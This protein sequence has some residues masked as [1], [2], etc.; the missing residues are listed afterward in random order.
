IPNRTETMKMLNG[1]WEW[2]ETSFVSRGVAPSQKTP[3]TTGR[4]VVVTFKPDNQALVFVQG[5]L[6]GTFTYKLSQ[7]P[8]DYV[9]ISFSDAMGNN[10]AKEFL[11]EG[12]LTISATELHIA[13]GY[14]DAGSNQ[15]F[16]KIET[17]KIPKTKRKKRK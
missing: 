6:S 15:K 13:G 17:E 8:N 12:P 3:E 10:P 2:L 4:K 7:Q 9:L 11:E 1:S 14:N 16:R 5:K